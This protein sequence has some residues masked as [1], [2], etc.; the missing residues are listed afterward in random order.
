MTGSKNTLILTLSVLLL[1][2]ASAAAAG[3][4]S[5]GEHNAFYA[6]NALYEKGNYDEAAKEYA[7]ILD[8]GF[9]SGPLY[10]NLGNTFFKQGKL[11]YAILAYRKAQKLMPGNSDLKANLRYAQSLT[12]DSA[13]QAPAVN[14]V[15]LFIE[16]PF[17]DLT[18]NTVAVISL[19]LYLFVMI[20][21]IAGTVNSV[22]GR[23]VSFFFYLFLFVFIFSLAAF[24]FRFYDEEFTRHGIV[25][26]KEA[27]CK[28]EP[29]DNSSTYFTL[30]EGQDVN[31][32]KER[33]GW[34][35]I[36]R[37]DGKLGWVKS[38]AVEEIDPAS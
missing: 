12:E 34:S 8:S 5:Q 24:A 38:A 17:R 31:V 20:C 26:G 27:E 6:A 2:C 36:R 3:E 21:L 7:R 23:R 13:F 35:R 1:G 19:V 22:F 29:I 33:N 28:Y 18:L 37:I 25:V 11:G 15:V 32:L 10:Y 30:K 9:E 14:R 16:L 4:I